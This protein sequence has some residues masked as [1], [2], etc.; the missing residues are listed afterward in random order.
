MVAIAIQRSE[1]DPIRGQDF[2]LMTSTGP[3]IST[4]YSQPMGGGDKDY[5]KGTKEFYY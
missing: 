3:V 5:I 4:V 1:P 2:Y